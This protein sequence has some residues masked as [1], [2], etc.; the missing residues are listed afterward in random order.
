MASPATTLNLVA[1]RKFRWMRRSTPLP[2]A[3]STRGLFWAACT[4]VAGLLLNID[5][6]PAHV[7]VISLIWVAWR[8]FVTYRRTYLPGLFVRALLAVLFVGDILLRFHTLN[9][10][11]AGTALLIVMG[12]LKL[13]ETRTQRDQFIVIA[14]AVFLLL[15]ACLD[16]QGLVRAPL[17]LLHAWLCCAALAVVASAPTTPNPGTVSDRGIVPI[18]ANTTVPLENRAALLLAA[19]SLAFALPLAVAMFLLFPRLPGAFWAIPRSDEALTGLGDTMSPGSISMLTS[20]YEVAFRAHFEG[21]PPPPQERYW[22]GPVLHEFDGFTWR[23]SMRSLAQVAP[24]QYLGTAY[25]YRLS[26]EPSSQ[27]WWFALDTPTGSPEPDCAEPSR[28]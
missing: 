26:M 4:Y 9:G 16:R 11:S 3:G 6:V 13:L 21:P 10:L 1:P 19:R 20:S 22:R 14:S 24:L 23:R 8:L 7:A 25:R 2:A 17:Y 27:R 5:R 28:Q 18:P 12:A 15:A